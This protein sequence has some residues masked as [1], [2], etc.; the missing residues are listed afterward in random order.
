M[1]MLESIISRYSN[2]VAVGVLLLAGLISAGHR[3]SAQTITEYYNNTDGTSNQ[4]SF[5]MGTNWALSFS[6]DALYSQQAGGNYGTSYRTLYG[7]GNH[8]LFKFV[9]KAGDTKEYNVTLN[10]SGYNQWSGNGS[11]SMKLLVGGD[12]YGAYDTPTATFPNHSDDPWVWWKGDSAGLTELASSTTEGGFAWNNVTFTIPASQQTVYIMVL[13]SANSYGY[14]YSA[15]LAFSVLP[16]TEYYNNGINSPTYAMGTNWTLS[17]S[18]DVVYSQNAGF[19]AGTS[20]R[21]LYGDGNHLLFKFVRQIGDTN[22]YSG[23]INLSGYNQWSGSGSPSMKLLV[24]GDAYGANDNPT[25]N[26]GW[27]WWTAD[28][29]NMTELASSTAGGSFAWNDVPFTIPA[30]QTNAYIMVLG[31]ANSYGYVYS[32]D[33]SFAGLPIKTYYN[34]GSSSPS[35]GMGTNW[36]LSL[37]TDMLYC[38][39][40]GYLVSNHSYRFDYGAGNNLLFKFVR[41]PGDANAYNVTLNMSGYN[42]WNASGS[43]SMKLLA[44]G[45]AYGT[46]DSPT[47]SLPNHSTATWEWWRGFTGNLT[48]LASSTADGGFNW[49]NLSFTIAADQTNAYVIVLGSANS[50]GYVYSADAVFTLAAPPVL[51][52]TNLGGGQLQFSWTGSGILQSQTNSLS[53]GL[54][55]NWFDYPEGG[56]SPVTVPVDVS[57]GSVFFRVKQ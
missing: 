18:P 26:H 45:D 35:Y 48:E 53:T 40:T 49:N 47:A 39:N 43:P 41:Q 37:S 30:D 16:I 46:Y 57:M 56:T 34:N 13:G 36:T 14:V 23:V 8:L 52:V 54:G 2:R 7:D 31:S 20:Y 55:T 15:S 1:K 51:S 12:T 11:P 5:A 27:V 19:N 24:G 10:L 29:V 38:Q 22:A 25:A 17:F 33:V 44:G 42:Q 6:P 32:A 50:Y 4:V 3:A 21:T 28:T 9:R